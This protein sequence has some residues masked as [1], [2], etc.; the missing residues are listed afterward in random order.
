MTF[1]KNYTGVLR[2]EALKYLSNCDGSFLGKDTNIICVSSNHMP[3]NEFKL[4][5]LMLDK[6]I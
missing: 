1:Q 3:A 5:A 2:V 4:A 6:R